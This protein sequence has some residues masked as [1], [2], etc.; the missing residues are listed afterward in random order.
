MNITSIK[1]VT[2]AIVPIEPEAWRDYE[3][4]FSVRTL[5]KNEVLWSDKDVCKHIIF[6]NKGLLK[7]YYYNDDKEIIG[8]FIFENQ[9]YTDYYSFISQNPCAVNHSAL[10]ETEII[11][12]PRP[13]IYSLYDKHKSFERLGRLIAE[14]NFIVSMKTQLKLKSLSPEEK[15]L[16]LITERPKVVERV[17]LNMIASYLNMTPEHLSRIRKKLARS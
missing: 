4:Y 10:E 5:K 9:Y 7:Y 14:Q 12:I 8:Q 3:Q 1:N 2:N 13:A 16:N 15:Y 11:M 6:I 17:P